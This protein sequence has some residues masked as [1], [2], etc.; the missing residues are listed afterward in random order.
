MLRNIIT[1]AAKFSHSQ[2]EQIKVFNEHIEKAKKITLSL[3]DKPEANYENTHMQKK[4]RKKD[5]MAF[6]VK[7]LNFTLRA[8]LSGETMQ[9]EHPIKSPI[10]PVSWLSCSS[11]KSMM[12]KQTCN[13]KTTLNEHFACSNLIHLANF[14]A[15][16]AIC[17]FFAYHS[18]KPPIIKIHLLK[19]FLLK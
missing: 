9:S 5:S 13:L 17:V 8:G 1:V 15:A 12:Q 19:T 3:I 6:S 14:S 16:L 4:K 2:W 10:S 11:I 7:Q 18:L